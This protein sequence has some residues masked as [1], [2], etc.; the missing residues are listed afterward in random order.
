MKR[1]DLKFS[2]KVEKWHINTSSEELTFLFAFN[3]FPAFS[4]WLVLVFLNNR[5]Q[6][7]PMPHFYRVLSRVDSEIL[8]YAC[9]FQ[10]P[11]PL[12]PLTFLWLRLV[13]D[14]YRITAFS[15]SENRMKK[16]NC[17]NAS[18]S[19]RSGILP[20]SA[21]ECSSLHWARTL[22]RCSNRWQL[23]CLGLIACD[24]GGN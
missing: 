16:W 14:L 3:C 4:R 13:L 23:V 11:H 12:Q 20:S 2:G 6:F 18:K 24:A 7:H 15:M 1:Y 19:A 10:C 8:H 5:H 21:G 22:H 9:E 17:K